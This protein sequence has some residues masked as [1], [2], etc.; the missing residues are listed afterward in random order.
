MSDR[1]PGSAL[2]ALALGAAASVLAVVL[3]RRASRGGTAAAESPARLGSPDDPVLPLAAFEP[4]DAPP[5]PLEDLP[6]AP[7]ELLEQAVVS[8]AAGT[9]GAASSETG[10]AV[11]PDA[12]VDWPRP[13]I[14]LDAGAGA[15]PALAPSVLPDAAAALPGDAAALP[16]DAVLPD[17]AVAP[18]AVVGRGKPRPIADEAAAAARADEIVRTEHPAYVGAQRTVSRRTDFGIERYVVTYTIIGRLGS[19]RI[20]LDPRS[21]RHMVSTTR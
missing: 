6:A 5:T 14:T 8:D 15:S 3:R 9:S 13:D 17:A 12:A 4:P 7:D 16:G 10:P 20:S 2:R 18:D 19:L 11:I 1:R 21:G